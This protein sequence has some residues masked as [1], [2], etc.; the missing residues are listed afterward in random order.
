M[1]NFNSIALLDNINELKTIDDE[2]LKFLS[3]YFER[4]NY[5]KNKCNILKTENNHITENI[6]LPQDQIYLLNNII[7]KQSTGKKITGK[8]ITY[9]P[10]LD[11]KNL[12][13]LTERDDTNIILKEL[14]DIKNKMH[15][16]EYNCK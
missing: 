12:L 11:K 13:K 9:K 3:D 14:L 15:I 4:D 2:K 6:S 5:I 10:V 16:L 8:K 7:S 1:D